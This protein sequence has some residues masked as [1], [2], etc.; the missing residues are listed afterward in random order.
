MRLHL[1]AHAATAAAREARFPDDEPLDTGGRR[2]AAEL[3]GRLPE[4]A[5]VWCAPSARCR[6]TAALVL[7]GRSVDGEAPAGPDPGAWAGRAPADLAVEDPA[8]LQSWLTDPDAAP[9][10]GESLAALVARV[11]AWMDDLPR[12][13]RT[14]GLAVV[15]P[16]VVRAAVAHAMGAG[17][18]AAWR[19]DVAPLTL[20]VLTGGSGRWNLRS[21]G[22]VGG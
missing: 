22:A 5:H 6:G 21:L 8:A 1:L 13:D 12:E 2:A 15:D 16:P 9:P 3:A 14:V 19:V 4:P 11:G 10:G 7:P 17:P 18:A 20:A